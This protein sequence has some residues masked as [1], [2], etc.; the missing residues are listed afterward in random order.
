[1]PFLPMRADG[2]LNE[3]WKLHK[4]REEKPDGVEKEVKNGLVKKQ[5]ILRKAGGKMTSTEYESA[6]TI[7]MTSHS[8]SDPADEHRLSVMLKYFT[9]EY[10]ASCLS[11]AKY[12]GRRL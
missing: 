1:M 8:Q 9:E 4:R 10:H 7:L 12:G 3:R 6:F 5:M 11:L 2:H